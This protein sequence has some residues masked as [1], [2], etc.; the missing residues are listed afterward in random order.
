MAEHQFDETCAPR[1]DTASVQTVL[2]EVIGVLEGLPDA[3]VGNSKVHFDDALEGALGPSLRRNK[4]CTGTWC[5][6]AT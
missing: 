5:M 2:A 1:Q 4:C 3:S 6:F